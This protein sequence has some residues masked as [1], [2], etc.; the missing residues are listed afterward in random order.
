MLGIP[1]LGT[2]MNEHETTPSTPSAGNL[3]CKD[4]V[5]LRKQLKSTYAALKPGSSRVSKTLTR[6]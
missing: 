6:V 2:P 1:R 3:D 4:I 5:D